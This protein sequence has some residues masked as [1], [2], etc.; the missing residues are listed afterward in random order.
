M[1]ETRT[2]QTR[3]HR[4]G[5]KGDRP[6]ATSTHT[7]DPATGVTFGVLTTWLQAWTNCHTTVKQIERYAWVS[8]LSLVS[9]LLSAVTGTAI[10]ATLQ[11]DVGTA[12]RV[13]VA[14]VAVVAALMTAAQAWVAGQVKALSAQEKALH[15]LHR[16]ILGAIEGS[17]RT[18]IT[19]TDAAAWEAEM[20]TLEDTIIH[21]STQQFE[22]ELSQRQRA[23]RVILEAY[24]LPVPRDWAQ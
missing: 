9:A 23:A 5:S 15:Q 24:N 21:T 7:V 16:R 13:I 8:K 18:P 2:Q 1:T 22:A 20:T 10:F 11:D 6:A 3:P 17:M 19:A 12:A 14:T 4:S